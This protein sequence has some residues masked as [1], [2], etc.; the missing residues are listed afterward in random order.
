MLVYRLVLFTSIKPGFFKTPLRINM[1]KST[2]AGIVG[3]LLS[4]S[5]VS[6]VGG[7][8]VRRA[9]GFPG[10]RCARWLLGAV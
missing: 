1:V 6:G 4:L 2:Y 9:L 7:G 5:G 10:V 3:G 8:P